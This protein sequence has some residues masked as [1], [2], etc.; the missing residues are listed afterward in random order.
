MA[1]KDAS[2]PVE[3]P[4][5]VHIGGE[6]LLDRLVPHMKQIMIGIAVISVVL[7]VIFTIRWLRERSQIAATRLAGENRVYFASIEQGRSS[8]SRGGIG[9]V[10]GDKG[11]KAIVV[12]G[13]K[14]INVA[15][16]A[17]FMALCNEVLKYIKFRNENPIPGVMPIL[18]GLGSPQEMKVTLM[19]SG[20]LRISCGEIP[21]P[22]EKISGTTKSKSSGRRLR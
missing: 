12:R 2:K 18:A 22:A 3:P 4:K 13:T 1:E 6:S 20:T 21:A 5:P 8:A 17:E 16:P 7:V 9:A 10:M 15:Q 11:V 19:K 14:D